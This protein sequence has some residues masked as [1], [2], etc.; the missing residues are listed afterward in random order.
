MPLVVPPTFPPVSEPPDSND[1][2]N[3]DARADTYLDEQ[4]TIVRPA[5]IAIGE[6]TYQNALYAEGR[7]EAAATSAGTAATQVALAATQVG[8]ANT[9]RSQ[10]E[11]AAQTAL[12]AP[13]TSGTTAASLAI[14]AGTKSFTTQ[15]G[16]A[17]SVGQPV[18]MSRTA[19][20]TTVQ[21]YGTI[22]SYNPST[23]EMS[24]DVPV[25][26]LVGSGTFSDW[27]IALTG[28]QGRSGLLPVVV[29]STNTV[30]V[31][32]FCYFLTAACTLTAPP[33]GPDTEEFEFHDLSGTGAAAVDFGA[34]KV[35]TF[36]GVKT[37][38]LMTL[39]PNTGIRLRS[40][41]FAAVGYLA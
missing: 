9:A 14:S 8:L 17:W 13:G 5:I 26:G 12:L 19:S 28:R 31:A 35:T 3:F 10:A 41:G 40:S 15:T 7:A 2:A 39:E 34:T 16:K 32:G 38:G 23:G 21:M 24:I 36:T 27:T 25:S 20:P 37:P 22:A 33:L 6:A 29:I 4:R 1:M 11:A 30:G 18:V